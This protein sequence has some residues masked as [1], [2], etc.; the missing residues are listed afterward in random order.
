MTGETLASASHPDPL[1]PPAGFR[2][3]GGMPGLFYR[4]EAAWGGAMLLGTETIGVAVFNGGYALA[5]VV[6]R[7]CGL[8]ATGEEVFCLDVSRDALPRGRETTIEVPSYEVPAP[9]SGLT[10]SLVSGRY[11]SPE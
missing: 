3:V 5:D 9:A 2:A 11:A 1:D 8:D 6:L 10:V 4:W 7:I